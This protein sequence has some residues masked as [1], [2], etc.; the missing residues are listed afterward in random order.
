MANGRGYVPRQVLVKF[1]DHTPQNMMY[2]QVRRNGVRVVGEVRALDVLVLGVPQ[3]Q[4]QRI[5]AALSR[6][7]NVEY[8]EP[9]YGGSAAFAPDDPT[10]APISGVLRRPDRTSRIKSGRPKP[11]CARLIFAVVQPPLALESAN[12][13]RAL[14]PCSPPRGHLVIFTQKFLECPGGWLFEKQGHDR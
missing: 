2:E 10:S 7:P 11:T 8:A 12:G 5:V 13:H 3:A 14:D 9:N 1:E 4:K 6:N